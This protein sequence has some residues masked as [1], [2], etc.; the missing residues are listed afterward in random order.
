MFIAQK[1]QPIM[2]DFPFSSF[3]SNSLLFLILISIS[4]KD[5]RDGIIP[6]IFLFILAFFGVLRF[7]VTHTMSAVILGALSYGLYKVYPLLRKQ[8]GLGLGDV[9]MMA[10]AGIWLEPFQLPLFLIISGGV[11]VG[12]ALLWHFLHK[13]RRF[14]LGPSL[15][16]ALGL[17]IVGNDVLSQGENEM[18]TTFS[19]PSLPPASGGKPNS[20]VVLIHGYGSNGE[21]L[22]ALGK[23]WAKVW[24]SEFPHTLFIAPNGPAPRE[25]SSFGNQWFSLMGWVP[26]QEST[27]DQTLQMLKEMQAITPSFNRY[28]D[29]LLKTYDLPPEKLALVGFSQG[30]MFALHVALHRPL[31]AGVVA[32][33]GSFL[34]DP[35]DVIVARPPILLVHGTADQLLPPSFSQK[36]EERLKSLH[37]PV[38]LSLLSGLDHG[39]DERGFKIGGIFLKERLA[40]SG[41]SDLLEKAKERR[42]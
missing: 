23:A 22:L 18:M 6:D 9:K 29:E 8:E 14:P 26:P 7:G 12:I 35:M 3:L 17:C 41:S 27:K 19:G 42:N 11:G 1:K 25:G 32:Y 38:T 39:I 40:E 4:V 2:M 28:L 34:N 33:S 36:A 31:C 20:L 24:A 15:A 16:L 5:V 30:A 37:V 13:G 21:D 10:V